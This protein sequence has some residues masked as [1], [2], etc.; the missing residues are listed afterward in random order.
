MAG[1]QL[2]PFKRRTVTFTVEPKR[3]ISVLKDKKRIYI[4][5]QVLNKSLN[6]KHLSLSVVSGVRRVLV[7]FVWHIITTEGHRLFVYYIANIIACLLRTILKHD[8]VF[9][10][11]RPA[12]FFYSC[13]D[14]IL[15]LFESSSHSVGWG[16]HWVIFQVKVKA[17]LI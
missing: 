16:A 13:H 9:F 6:N 7:V 1:I 17:D 4:D 11:K 15:P 8:L 12:P 2:R 3:Y 10:E 14:C 5:V